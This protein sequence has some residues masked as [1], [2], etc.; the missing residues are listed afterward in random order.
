MRERPTSEQATHLRG[1]DSDVLPVPVVFLD[2]DLRKLHANDAWRRLQL[3]ADHHEGIG[4]ASVCD[5]R[6]RARASSVLSRVVAGEGDATLVVRGSQ[7]DRWL[8]L[9]ASAIGNG[10]GED[11]VLVA[12]DITA[13]KER[14][15]MLAFDG[16]RDPLTG[17]HNRVAAGQHLQGALD[18][19]Q[20]RPS[21]LAVLFIDLD[22]FREVNREHGHMVGDR[23]LLI[24]A[25]KLRV[26][27]RPADLIAR[28]GGDEFV[29]VCESL[30]STKEAL[31][32]A[33]RLAGALDE[34]IDV[35]PSTELRLSATIGVAFAEG[36]HEEVAALLARADMA[37][38]TAKQQGR[39]L[40]HFPSPTAL[41]V[42]LTPVRARRDHLDDVAQKLADVESELAEGWA[43]SLLQQDPEATEMWRSACH[44]AS[45]ALEGLRGGGKAP[46]G[47]PTNREGV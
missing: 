11:L 35:S 9:R 14:E 42:K 36:P 23:V 32:V 13:Q 28:V 15:A 24:A 31:A 17:L 46:G 7:P 6:D 16:I 27:I 44:Y 2:R 45:L 47:S 29:A 38:Y 10:D 5:P 30:G 19:L 34:P 21:I 4:W 20:R 26:A 41:S 22:G 40:V 1:S 33:N 8:E 12:L 25:Q 39:G 43:G 18:R 37:M 3:D